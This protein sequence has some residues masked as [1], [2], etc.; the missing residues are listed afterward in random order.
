MPSRSRTHNLIRALA[1]VTALCARGVRAET[2]DSTAVL[3]PA[4]VR[5]WQTGVFRA[6]RLE[7]ASLAMTTGLAAGL[8]TREPAAAAATAVTLG[9]GK[10][11]WDMRRTHFDAGDLL[12]D[13][14]GAA[15]ATL[16]T[17]A[18]TRR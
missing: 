13:L 9:F 3:P 14:V 4:T 5:G 8:T 18:L 1:L 7:H 2:P 12:A 11:L 17:W 16:A 6:D 10:E 15:A